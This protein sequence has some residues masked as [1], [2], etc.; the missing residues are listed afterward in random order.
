V[1]LDES[2][3]IQAQA[4]SRSEI[5][6]RKL[7]RHCSYGP[8]EGLTNGTVPAGLESLGYISDLG[9]PL[10]PYQASCCGDSE[11]SFAND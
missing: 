9:L 5:G 11:N 10:A 8:H 6:M 2:R 1:V 3:A 7:G 4:I